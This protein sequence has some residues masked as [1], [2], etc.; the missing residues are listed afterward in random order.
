MFTTRNWIEMNYDLLYTT[1]RKII[2]DTNQ[3]DDFFHFILEDILRHEQ[4][5]DGLKDKEKMY[6]FVRVVK[7]QFFSKTSPYFY[8]IKRPYLTSETFED[9]LLD[10]PDE[11][12]EDYP[13]LA[14]V[15][16]QLEQEDW[17]YRDLFLL[18]IE[19]GTLTAVSK[20]TTIPLN[21]VGRYINKIKKKLQ[22][23]WYETKVD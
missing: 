16:E 1:T 14:W 3:L 17:F 22:K 10:I 4:K 12:K 20:K 9:T 2:K 13:P 15:Y 19:L 18:W 23:T 21:S 8:R 5:M 6:Y 11:Y 7:N